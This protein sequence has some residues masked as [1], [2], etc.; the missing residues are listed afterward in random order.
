VWMGSTR[1]CGTEARLR[2]GE[3]NWGVWRFLRTGVGVRQ[4]PWVRC[5]RKGK[6]VLYFCPGRKYTTL[7]PM[8]YLARRAET[9]ESTT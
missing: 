2:P 8:V 4:A 6:G 7:V 5:G 1:T 3:G 9:E